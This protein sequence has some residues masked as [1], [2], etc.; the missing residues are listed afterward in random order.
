MFIPLLWRFDQLSW[1]GHLMGMT[2]GC[3][4]GAYDGRAGPLGEEAA[5]APTKSVKAGE[6]TEKV[7][8]HTF[9]PTRTRTHACVASPAGGVVR[10]ALR[11]IHSPLPLLCVRFLFDPFVQTGLTAKEEEDTV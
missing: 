7:R 4:L 11:Q 1:E 5:P 8:T 6:V 2:I 3:V 9:R 10:V